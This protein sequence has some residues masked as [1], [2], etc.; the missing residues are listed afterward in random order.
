MS[1]DAAYIEHTAREEYTHSANERRV[2]LD[3]R[4]P[5]IITII[6]IV[7]IVIIIIIIIVRIVVIGTEE[8]TVSLFLLE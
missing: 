7:K 3:A 2:E 6:I 1:K 4:T 5:I 8:K